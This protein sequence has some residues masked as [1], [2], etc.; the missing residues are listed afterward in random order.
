[1]IGNEQFTVVRSAHPGALKRPRLVPAMFFIECRACGYE[2]ANQQSPPLA[3]CPRC[4]TSTWQ[5]LP[6]PGSLHAVLC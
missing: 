4:G 6:R 5:R 2:P 1:M 3:R